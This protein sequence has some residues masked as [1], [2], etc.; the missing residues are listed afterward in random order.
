MSQYFTPPQQLD[1]RC[2]YSAPE[3]ET[4]ILASR[5]VLCSSIQN[6]V[7]DDEIDIFA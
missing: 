5:S 3:A 2:S 4:L 6:L 7:E 1:K